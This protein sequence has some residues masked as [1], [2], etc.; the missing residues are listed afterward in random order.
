MFSYERNIIG[1][2]SNIKLEK[3]DIFFKYKIIPNYI[4]VIVPLYKSFN[5]IEMKDVFQ[6]KNKVLIG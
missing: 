4:I 1:N 2:F 5:L 3:Y 6:P